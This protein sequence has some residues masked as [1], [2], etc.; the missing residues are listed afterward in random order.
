M[1]GTAHAIATT[2]LLCSTPRGTLTL[3][4][5]LPHLAFSFLFSSLLRCLA[6]CAFLVV[7][8]ARLDVPEVLSVIGFC[9]RTIVTHAAQR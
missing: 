4:R 1:P 3:G 7:M 5:R 9:S 2:T 8:S 6:I